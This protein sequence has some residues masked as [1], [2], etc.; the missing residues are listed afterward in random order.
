[1]KVCAEAQLPSSELPWMFEL[2][3]TDPLLF[4]VRDAGTTEGI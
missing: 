2:K 3:E 4:T 1:M